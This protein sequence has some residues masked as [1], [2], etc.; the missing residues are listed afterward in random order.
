MIELP[1]YNQGDKRWGHLLLVDWNPNLTMSRWGCYITSLTM[2]L[3]AYGIHMTP[4]QV[5][6]RLKA[7]NGITNDGL[8]TYY[9]VEQAF[10]MV[11]FY[12]REYTD[13]DK[14]NRYRQM[15]VEKAI[16]NIRRLLDSGQPVIG[17]VDNVGDDDIPDHA[18]A[19]YDYIL[20]GDTVVDLM[21]GDPDG[22]KDIKFSTKYGEIRDELFGYVALIGP[23]TMFPDQSEDQEN[24]IALW[25][26]QELKKAAYASDWDRVKTYARELTDSLLV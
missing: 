17:T 22:G 7:V 14:D 24:G 21:I 23:P 2:V 26:S 16:H 18:I 1:I 12:G 9:G 3:R 5:L 8:L 4:D 13:N 11:H 15:T 20:D 10:P 19:I 25:K 6:Q